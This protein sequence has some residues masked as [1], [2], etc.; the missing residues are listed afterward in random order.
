MYSM[1]AIFF[2]VTV[3]TQEYRIIISDVIVE[4]TTI[5]YVLY[6]KYYLI[7]SELYFLYHLCDIFV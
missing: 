2:W 5:L 6:T 1:S 4:D 3:C 7:W